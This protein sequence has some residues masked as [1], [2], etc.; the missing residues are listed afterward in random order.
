M[1]P[2]IEKLLIDRWPEMLAKGV[3]PRS[4][5]VTATRCEHGDGW[6]GILD[7]LCAVL[8]SH[9]K[10][11]G[12]KVVGVSQVREE[13]G[14]LHFYAETTDPYEREAIGLTERYSFCVCELTG[15]PGRLSARDGQFRTLSPDRADAEGYA[16]DSERARLG[17]LPLDLRVIH[18][19]LVLRWPEVLIGPADI[20]VGWSDLADCLVKHIAAMHRSSAG[21]G[22]QIRLFDDGDNLRVGLDGDVRPS[23]EG[24]AAFAIEMSKRLHPATG[25]SGLLTPKQA[26]EQP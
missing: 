16:F 18:A 5:G 9:A 20:P 4:G 17:T 13:R 14:G 26:G 11:A 22:I 7:A 24:A 21:F 10:S 2:E 3:H 6:S 25:A 15:A 19:T 12:R 1:T 23:D 8:T